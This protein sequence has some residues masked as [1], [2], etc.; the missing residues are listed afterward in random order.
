MYILPQK[1]TLTVAMLHVIILDNDIHI[2]KLILI[3]FVAK[4][5]TQVIQKTDS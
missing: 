4:L 3:Y 5:L 1:M 2:A